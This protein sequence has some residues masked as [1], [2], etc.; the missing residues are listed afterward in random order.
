MLSIVFS[1]PQAGKPWH[2]NCKWVLIGC[3]DKESTD[4][5]GPPA[6][7]YISEPSENLITFTAPLPW[8]MC[9]NQ[10]IHY[11]LPIIQWDSWFPLMYIH[12]TQLQEQYSFVFNPCYI[13]LTGSFYLFSVVLTWSLPQSQRIASEKTWEASSC[14]QKGLDITEL[15]IISICL[16]FGASKLRP[17]II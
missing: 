11:S 8:K 5:G 2:C 12:A 9:K 3:T 16:N 7:M 1:T 13:V 4:P 6:K 15:F 14:R 17:D 10:L